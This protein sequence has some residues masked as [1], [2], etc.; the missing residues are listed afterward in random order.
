MVSVLWTIKRVFAHKMVSDIGERASWVGWIQKWKRGKADERI[1]LVCNNRIITLQY[2]K[3]KKSV[4]RNVHLFDLTE[5]KS[6]DPEKTHLVFRTFSIQLRSPRV[7]EILHAIIANYDAVT[8]PLPDHIKAAFHVTK[9]RLAIMRTPTSE[10]TLTIGDQVAAMFVSMCNYLNIYVRPSITEYLKAAYTS[11]N[12]ELDMSKIDGVTTADVQAIIRTLQFD[13][14]FSS[15]I[16][17][18]IQ[19]SDASVQSFSEMLSRNEKLEKLVMVDVGLHKETLSGLVEAIGGNT[20]L[21]LRYLDLSG[22]ALQDKG[23]VAL[24]HAMEPMAQKLNVIL[25]SNCSSGSK[26]TSAVVTALKNNRNIASSLRQLSI[27][28]NKLEQ[29]GSKLFADSFSSFPE[30]EDLDFAGTAADVEVLVRGFESNSA[31]LKLH[32]LNLSHNK[33]SKASAQT[34]AA[35]LAE[36]SGPFELHLVSTN[37]DKPYMEALIACVLCNEQLENVVLDISDNDLGLNLAYKI[38][39]MMVINKNLSTLVANNA[40]F[41]PEGLEALVT[42]LTS[43]PSLRTLSIDCNMKE[44]DP[45]GKNGRSVAECLAHFVTHT[46]S[47]QHLSFGGNAGLKHDLSPLISMLPEMTNLRYLSLAGNLLGDDGVTLLSHALRKNSALKH[48]SIGDNSFSFTALRALR[49][50]LNVNSTLTS[51]DLV[52]RFSSW[53][54][55]DAA[56]DKNVTAAEKEDM[57]MQIQQCLQRNTRAEKLNTLRRASNAIVI[58]RQQSAN[59]S[60]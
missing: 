44:R 25:L 9:E 17:R 40:D 47:L 12:K 23:L 18:E 22:N 30:L 2:S 55:E 56:M 15:I 51:L 20:S 27:A 34:L 16:I 41:T 42:A 57:L 33:I 35:W 11:K 45:R 46:P 26:G 28:G 54:S 8:S 53:T 31:G 29:K 10:S 1:L 21:P 32:R 19:L 6:E 39:S 49:H 14:H 36:R 13:A 3:L 59:F 52:D 58:G 5:I 38:A 7:D 43:H 4:C 50:A 48:L 37:I 60:V 24:G